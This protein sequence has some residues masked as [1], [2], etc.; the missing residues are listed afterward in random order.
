MNNHVKKTIHEEYQSMV[1][2]AISLDE[3]LFTLNKKAETIEQLLSIIQSMAESEEHEGARLYDISILSKL[4]I[5]ERYIPQY[6]DMDESAPPEK[7]ELSEQTQTDL[8]ERFRL[9]NETE[10]LKYDDTMYLVSRDFALCRP[11]IVENIQ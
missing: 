5:R 10:Q 7:V 3:K 4:A 11:R 1:Q 6:L 9:L 8:T 2:K